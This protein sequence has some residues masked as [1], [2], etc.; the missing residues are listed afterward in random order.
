MPVVSIKII[1]KDGNHGKYQGLLVKTPNMTHA[2]GA[3]KSNAIKQARLLRAIE[4]GWKPSRQ[5]R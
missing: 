4:H 5:T 1:K 3:S 2:K